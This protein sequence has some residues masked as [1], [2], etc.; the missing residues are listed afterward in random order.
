MV[1]AG[2]QNFSGTIPGGLTGSISYFVRATDDHGNSGV[3]GALQF[4][5]TAPVNYCT[6]GVSASGCQALISA[7]GSPSASAA[8]GFTLDTLG[9]EGQKD[10]MYYFGVSGQNANSWGNGTSYQ[11]VMFPVSRGGLL[12]GTGH[13]G[14][15]D[16]SFSQDL[17]ARWTAK[18][19]QNPGAGA[20]VQAQLWYRDPQN[21]SNQTTSLSDAVEFVVF[22]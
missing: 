6:A 9:I 13:A 7:N 16:G 17:N 1:F 15:C 3:S 20:V 22:P 11:C 5:A 4:A 18:P 8:S 19:N 10:G 2:G 14:A 12:L 21:T